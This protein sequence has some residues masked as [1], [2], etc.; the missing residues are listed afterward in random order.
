MGSV[1]FMAKLFSNLNDTAIVC[2]AWRRPHYFEKTLNHWAQVRKLE[3]VQSFT[4]ALGRSDAH[5]DQVNLINK[6]ADKFTA[7]GCPGG[8]VTILD[9]SDEAHASTGVHRAIAEVARHAF[10]TSDADFLVFGEEDILVSDDVLEYMAWGK[11]RFK[12][13]DRVLCICAHNRGGQGWDPDHTDPRGIRDEG[14]DEH[15]VRLLPYFNAWVWGTWRD[16]WTDIIEPQWDWDSTRAG[17]YD[18]NFQSRIIPEGD[19]LC[20]IPDASRSQNNGK[21]DGFYA[22]AD[23]FPGTQS[24]SFKEHRE[25]ADFILVNQ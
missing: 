7:R 17:G 3:E 8:F 24:K 2:T 11:D 23:L 22:H 20:A 12:A 19:Y 5:G 4:V 1:S 18:W 6:M 10:D 13:D 25:P 14:A 9:D 15:Q 21:D 16:R